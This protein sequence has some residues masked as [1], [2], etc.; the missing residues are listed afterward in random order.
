MS[1]P[2]RCLRPCLRSSLRPAPRAASSAYLR[3]Y[4]AVQSQVEPQSRI[5]NTTI[6]RRHVPTEYPR[7]NPQKEAIDYQTFHE[8]YRSLARGESSTDEVVVRGILSF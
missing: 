6:E 2:L 3:F 1:I 4:S 5:R 8:R 7:I